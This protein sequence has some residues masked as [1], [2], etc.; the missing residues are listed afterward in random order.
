[1]PVT[2]TLPPRQPLWTEGDSRDLGAEVL[3]TVSARTAAGRGADGKPLRPLADGSPSKLRRSGRLQASLEVEASGTR[4]SVVATVPYA[5][6][7]E[8]QGR[9]FLGLTP[10]EAAGVFERVGDVIALRAG[11]EG[12]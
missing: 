10:T 6:H 9:P 7:V 5:R 4:A 3:A 11:A 12:T 8:A 1:M 2:L